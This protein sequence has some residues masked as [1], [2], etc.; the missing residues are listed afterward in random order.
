MKELDVL[1]GNESHEFIKRNYVILNRAK[2]NKGII[3]NVLLEM[4]KNH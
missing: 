2:K 4:P 1:T 3:T